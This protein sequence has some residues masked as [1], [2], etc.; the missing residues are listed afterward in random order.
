MAAKH[1][2]KLT[3]LLGEKNKKVK[4]GAARPCVKAYRST[5]N[6]LGRRVVLKEWMRLSVEEEKRGRGVGGGWVV[7]VVVR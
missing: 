6:L 5:L 2:S 7:V 4:F 3:G 1:N